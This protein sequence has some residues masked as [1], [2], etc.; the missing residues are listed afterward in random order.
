MKAKTE[1]PSGRIKR[2]FEKLSSYSMKVGYRKGKTMYIADYVATR[3][4]KSAEKET[5]VDQMVPRWFNCHLM[6]I[7]S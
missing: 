7:I 6:M 2:L 4:Q 1:P 5:P 3:A